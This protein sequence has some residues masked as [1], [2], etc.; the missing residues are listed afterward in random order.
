[1]IK[2]IEKDIE[3]LQNVYWKK[4]RNLRSLTMKQKKKQEVN[5]RVSES[6]AL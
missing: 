6:I 3:L 1:M 2:F 5:F 4:I